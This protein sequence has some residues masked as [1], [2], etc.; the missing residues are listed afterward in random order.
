MV[1]SWKDDF[2]YT[3]DLLAARVRAVL[4]NGHAGQLPGAPGA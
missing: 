1:M 2:N 4:M 3:K